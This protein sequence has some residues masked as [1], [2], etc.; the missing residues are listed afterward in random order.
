VRQFLAAPI[1]GRRETIPAGRGPIR[2]GFLPAGRGGDVSVLERCPE[3]VTNSV[4]WSDHVA[5]IASGFR[6]DGIHRLLI[7][8]AVDPLGQC[9][10]QAG[11]VL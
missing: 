4:E 3:F 9:I 1:G 10:L 7:K 11:G 5:G 2:I 6:Q 8:I